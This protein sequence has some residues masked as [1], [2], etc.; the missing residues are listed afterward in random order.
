MSK[1][2]LIEHNTHEQMRWAGNDD[3]REHLEVGK[4]YEAIEEVLSFHT[5]I[6]INGKKFNSVCFHEVA[7][8]SESQQERIA[9]LEA[10][11]KRLQKL[12]NIG[13]VLKAN[14]IAVDMKARC[15]ALEAGL[16][17]LINELDAKDY[18]THK[19]EIAIE[20]SK[21]LLAP[22]SGSQEQE[23]IYDMDGNAHC[24]YRPGFTNMMEC[25]CGFGD[26]KEEALQD[27]KHQEGEEFPS[28]APASRD[29]QKCI[30]PFITDG[31]CPDCEAFAEETDKYRNQWLSDQ[32][33]IHK[34]ES[35]L[36]EAYIQNQNMHCYK[37]TGNLNKALNA[38]TEIFRSLLAN[39]SVSNPESGA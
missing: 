34:L 13:D 35:V 18:S 2:K 36:K 22:Q 32:R 4:V 27:L 21:S 5:N 24:A 3:T 33:R 15:A 23:V 19:L 11:N 1:F 10:E 17:N 39:T 37:T 14:K 7:V 28:K 16:Q 26:S 9:E 8:E 29:E 25:H 30:H 12:D 31:V 38:Q 6:I 20:T